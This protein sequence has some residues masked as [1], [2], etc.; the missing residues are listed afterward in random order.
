MVAKLSF[1]G[2]IGRLI[3]IADQFYFLIQFVVAFSASQTRTDSTFDRGSVGTSKSTSFSLKILSVNF[4]LF[5]FLQ[6]KL[7][8]VEEL[9]RRNFYLLLHSIFIYFESTRWLQSD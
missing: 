3:S 8:H 7:L 5:S 4:L 6:N 2:N 1:D 9:W